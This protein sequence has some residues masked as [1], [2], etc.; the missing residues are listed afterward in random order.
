M[1]GGWCNWHWLYP[2]QM[3][4][5]WSWII[6]LNMIYVIALRTCESVFFET[7]TEFKVM[8]LQVSAWEF[9]ILLAPHAFCH[10]RKRLDLKP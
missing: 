7:N 4:V 10:D 1:T 3:I 8:L 2:H 9:P 5:F 6:Q